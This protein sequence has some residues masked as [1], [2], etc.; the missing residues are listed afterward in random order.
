[1]CQVEVSIYSDGE[2]SRR[3]PP[4]LSR[5]DFHRYTE[6]FIHCTYR[7][8]RYTNQFISFIDLFIRSPGTS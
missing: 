6:Q 2:P 1:M 7:F 5:K 3:N 8:I 4:S